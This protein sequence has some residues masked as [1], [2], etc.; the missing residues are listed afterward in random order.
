MLYKTI[1]MELLQD[2]PQIYDQLLKNRTLLQTLES[3][4]SELRDR[5]L[6][7][8]ELLSQ[9]RPGSNPTL[10]T[11]EALELAIEELMKDSPCS[12]PQNDDEPLS[13]DGAM[14]FIRLHSNP[15]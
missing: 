14:T 1:V 15:A 2:R 5:H 11:S 9:A 3:Y 12:Q 6:A 10:I 8:K 13:L 7:W 4:A